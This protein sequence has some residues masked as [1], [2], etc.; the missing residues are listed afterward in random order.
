MG[1]CQSNQQPAVVAVNDQPKSS[2]QSRQESLKT[3]RLDHKNAKEVPD[4]TPSDASHDTMGMTR[5][6]SD[7]L[8]GLH[9]G[10]RTENNGPIS[11]EAIPTVVSGVSILPTDEESDD[12]ES[13]DKFPAYYPPQS[14]RRSGAVKDYLQADGAS[15]NRAM[16]HIETPLGIPI[17]AVYDGVRDGEVLGEGIAGVVRRI[18]HK[19]TGIQR[20]VKRLDLE[21]VT[22]DEDLDR[23]LDEIKIMC[24]LDHPNVV[25]LEEVYEGEKE[26]FLTQDLCRGGDLFDRLDNQSNFCYTEDGCARLIRQII[27]SVSYLHS[28]DIIH[29]DLKLEN[30]L[31]QDKTEGSEL[32]MIDFGLSKHFV[33]GEIQH[34]TVGTPY[35]VAPEVILGKGYDEKCD[36]WGIGVIAYLLLSGDTPFG[37][38][39]EDDDM[40]EVKKNIL[41]GH[42]SFEGE[43][44]DHVSKA[45]VDF[46]KSLLRLDPEERPRS[47]ELQHH[48]WIKRMKRNSSF[49][50]VE[51]SLSAK[52][53]NGLVSFKELST[54]RK[55]LREIISYTLQPDQISGLRAEFE[56][57]DVHDKGEI[58]LTCFKEALIA[59]S[60]QHPLSEEEI[61]AIFNGLKVRNTDL[62]IRWHEFIAACLS[63]CQI[64][65]RNIRL[66]FDRLDNDR[67]GFVT[68]K[69]FQKALDF[70]GSDSRYD[71]QSIWI[72][73]VIDY[74]SDK[75]HMTYDDF[76]NLLKLDKE[77][78]IS[79]PKTLLGKPTP[80]RRTARKQR[81][82]LLRSYTTGPKA[83]DNSAGLEWLKSPID[84]PSTQNLNGSKHR[85]RSLGPVRNLDLNKIL[86]EDDEEEESLISNMKASR[87]IHSFILE[88][89][90]RVEEEQKGSQ[91]EEKK[92]SKKI[93]GTGGLFLRRESQEKKP[94]NLLPSR[95]PQ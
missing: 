58:S 28:K 59:N 84:D 88:A 25:C 42:V 47:S 54:T 74:K 43:C 14:R 48:Q 82:A 57:I 92:A 78:E 71:L 32:I 2:V 86:F 6:S 35:T 69:D 5:D 46:I 65:D 21:L 41:S 7:Y 95:S 4:A 24:C 80:P 56:K 27:S 60:D 68:L 89:S 31:F 13:D 61:E 72:N 52:V 53:V 64:D 83:A 22:S 38:A 63:Q 79:S 26:L 23:L 44:W 85:R 77:K 19:D 11:E 20:A 18:T 29:R 30:F 75:D 55:F 81:S 36:V 8:E 91:K 62:S 49:G 1:A 33:R 51:L 9:H 16:V 87:D 93:S 17:E 3:S 90:K 39:C 45:A 76:Y 70:Y 10:Q 50:A 15:S 40:A 73:N 94:A 12:R 66:A 34:E 67:K 37:G